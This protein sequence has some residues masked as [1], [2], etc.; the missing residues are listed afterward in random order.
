MRSKLNVPARALPFYKLVRSSGIHQK[1]TIRH[2]ASGGVA[3]TST[4][5]LGGRETVRVAITQIPPVYMD[6]DA[7]V[8]RACDAI[9]AAARDGAELLAFSESWLPGYPTW[10]EGWDMPIEEWVVL[11]EI[12]QDCAIT[13]DGP[14]TNRLLA[15][16]NAGKVNVV[17]GV[18]ELDPRPGAGSIY[19]SLFFIDR[20]GHLAGVHR[21]L[22][23]FAERT[24]YGPGSPDAGVVE[25]DIGRVGGLICGEMWMASRKARLIEQGQD[26]HVASW[27]GAFSYDG[28]G[29]ND[30]EAVNGTSPTHSSGRSYACDAGAFVLNAHGWY[31]PEDLKPGFPSPEK[32]HLWPRGGSA[33]F[34]PSGQVLVSPDYESTIIFADCDSRSIKIAKGLVDLGG[35]I[36]LGQGT[37]SIGETDRSR[38]PGHLSKARVTE[39]ADRLGLDGTLLLRAVEELLDQRRSQETDTN[40]TEAAVSPL[41]R[42]G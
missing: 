36:P 42:T 16:A 26:F 13:L 35:E 34:G 40:G 11:R 32:L 9:D 14:E 27:V 5:F 8:E 19:D 24:F 18:N 3:M 12:W 7:S 10:T 21:K 2:T 28:P 4:K 38:S 6:K 30:R 31:A 37:M 39:V 20:R 41:G 23:L 29:V 25:F 33:V 15:A 1:T 22:C 17:I